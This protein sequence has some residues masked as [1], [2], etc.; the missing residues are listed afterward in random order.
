MGHDAWKSPDGR[1][2]L[3]LGRWQEVLADIK[4]CAACITDPPYSERTAKGFKTSPDYGNATPIGEQPGVKYGYL[5][6]LEAAEIA[7]FAKILNVRWLCVFGCHKTARW[8]DSSAEYHGRYVFA[9]LAYIRRNAAPR[10]LSD[11]PQ[12]CTDWLTVSRIRKGFGKNAWR[13]LRGWYSGRS[14]NTGVIGAK[15]IETMRQIVRDYSNPGDLIV[16]LYAGSG[17]TL[18]AAA[19]EGRRAIGAEMD[20]KT[21]ALAV[22][23]LSAGYTPTFV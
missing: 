11:G 3:R 1:M 5:T 2:E 7:A 13:S 18:L 19:I 4:S 20:P 9:P 22:R 15:D 8:H 23:R 21:Y 17:T 12:S 10:F 16:D 6:E 14:G